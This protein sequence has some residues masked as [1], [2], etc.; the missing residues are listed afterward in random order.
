MYGFFFFFFFQ[1]IWKKFQSALLNPLGRSTGNRFLSKGG[2]IYFHF[3]I[4][5]DFHPWTHF[6]WRRWRTTVGHTYRPRCSSVWR[7]CRRRRRSR[8]TPCSWGPSL[9]SVC[10]TNTAASS[11]K[12]K[13]TCLSIILDHN[14]LASIVSFNFPFFQTTRTLY[15]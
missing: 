7:R 4:E 9:T 5:L 3:F 6:S 1:K 15:H 10:S 13:V 11:W 14:A 8:R 12:P 2:F